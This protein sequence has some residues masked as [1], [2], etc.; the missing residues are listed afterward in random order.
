MESKWIID[1]K[2]EH[3]DLLTINQIH[4]ETLSI[5]QECDDS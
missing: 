4:F 2:H 3:K 5:A 1:L